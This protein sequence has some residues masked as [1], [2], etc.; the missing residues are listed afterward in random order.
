MS[1]TL[2][3][4]KFRIKKKDGEKI[5]GLRAVIGWDNKNISTDIK[6]DIDRMYYEYIAQIANYG[7]GEDYVAMV[8]KSGY[9]IKTNYDAKLAILGWWNNFC[10]VG[11]GSITADKMYSWLDNPIMSLMIHTACGIA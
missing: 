10:G 7:R 6:N 1:V 8:K 9:N 5:A 2:R 11:S 4:K 3:N